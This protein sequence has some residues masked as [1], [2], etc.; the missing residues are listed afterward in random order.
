MPEN[1]RQ[2]LSTVL[3]HLP[4]PALLVQGK[5]ISYCNPTATA[6]TFRTGE[7]VS[8][9]LGDAAPFYESYN[10]DGT[11]ALSFR[12]DDAAYSAAIHRQCGMD[13]FLITPP[14]DAEVRSRL[15]ATSPRRCASRSPACFTRPRPCSPPWKNWRTPMFRPRPLP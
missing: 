10:G 2:I 6:L 15:L 4:T 13:I 3:E 11:I 5:T 7:P 12:R 1:D 9:L 8:A 14:T